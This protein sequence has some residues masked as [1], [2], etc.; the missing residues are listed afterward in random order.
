MGTTNWRSRAARAVVVLGALALVLGAAACGGDDGGSGGDD[1]S[2]DTTAP[3]G[4]GDDDLYVLITNSEGIAAQS[5]DVLVESVFRQ[6]GTTT[7][8]VTPNVEAVVPPAPLAEGQVPS[9]L[10]TPTASG[11]PG[12]VVAADPADTV[13]SAVA[14]TIDGL[15][16]GQTT[17]DLVIAGINTGQLI[18]S[19]ADFSSNVPAAQAA[20]EAGIPAL[21]VAQ[22]VDEAVPDYASGATQALAWIDE[23]RDALLAGEE[24]AQVTLLNVPSC[25]SGQVR[26]VV[27]VPVAAD[28]A[29]RSLAT[30]DCNS[31]AEDPVDDVAAFTTGYATVS[32]LPAADATTPTTAAAPPTTG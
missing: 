27:E 9:V 7:A 21:V 5:L 16:E 11:F 4:G 6:P 10:F 24:P 26:G 30:V 3:A 12:V 28:D 22:G 8:V 2:A 31:T 19:L 17:P 29:G 13:R 32:V 20:V 23:H 15:P 1:A 18:G 25:A 14:G